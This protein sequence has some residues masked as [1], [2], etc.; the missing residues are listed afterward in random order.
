MVRFPNIKPS[1][2]YQSTAPRVRE[3]LGELPLLRGTEKQIAWANSIRDEMLDWALVYYFSHEGEDEKIKSW[4]GR[5][6]KTRL[7]QAISGVLWERPRDCVSLSDAKLLPKKLPESK[8][9]EQLPEA[10][11][12]FARRH[13]DS[14]YWIENTS[15]ANSAW[16]EWEN[17]EYENNFVFDF[18]V[19]FL[20]L[21]VQPEK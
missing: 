12:A 19:F 20:A 8:V 9:V 18:L 5:E 16:D 1:P 7:H 6:N 3:C 11:K 17:R 14:K 4:R 10:L 13:R 2:K 21:Y 15:R